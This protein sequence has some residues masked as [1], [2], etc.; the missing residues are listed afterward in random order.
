MIVRRVGVVSTTLWMWLQACKIFD[1]LIGLN[2]S[3]RLLQEIPKHVTSDALLETFSSEAE[4]SCDPFYL[5]HRLPGGQQSNLMKDLPPS[6]HP[7][8]KYIKQYSIL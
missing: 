2:R 8:H 5:P 7:V 4:G 1:Y 3:L 6:D